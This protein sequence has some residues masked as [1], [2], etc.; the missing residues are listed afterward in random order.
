[1]RTAPIARPRPYVFSFLFLVVLVVARPAHGQVTLV[2]GATNF[3]TV[4]VATPSVSTLTFQ[5]TQ[6]FTLFQVP[7]VVTQGQ[8]NADF[9][10]TGGSCGPARWHAGNTCTVEVT[11]TPAYPGARMGAVMFV[12]TTGAIAATWNLQGVGNGSLPPGTGTVTTTNT[13][14]A[15]NALVV[16]AKENV[17]LA[18]FFGVYTMDGTSLGS[19][20]SGATNAAGID[21][22]GNIYVTDTVS[23]CV[24]L[25]TPVL[26]LGS[27]YT[28]RSTRCL[29]PPSGVEIGPPLAVDGSGYLYVADRVSGNVVKFNSNGSGAV[30]AG[31]GHGTC[32]DSYRWAG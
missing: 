19:G 10:M 22:A 14:I 13:P 28:K 23:N 25:T 7:A 6:D 27:S 16:D 20:W 3:G 24:W 11:F 29:S 26:P 32:P 18:G 12:S 15:A 31:C 17:Y 2:S 9:N 8:F 4:S 5:F 1:M 21:G 30:V